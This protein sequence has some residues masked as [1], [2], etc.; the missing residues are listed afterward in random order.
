MIYVLRTIFF[1]Y[2]QQIFPVLGPRS[3][4]PVKKNDSH[5]LISARTATSVPW[6][7]P[8]DTATSILNILEKYRL[9]NPQAK[10]EPVRTVD[11][12]IFQ[13]ERSMAGG[14]P[15][16]MVLPAFPFKSANKSTKVLGTLPDKGEEVALTHLNNLCE[17]IG[18]VYK[19]GAR[20]YIISDGLVYNDILKVSDEEVWRYGQQLRQLA[21]ECGCDHLRFS[22]LCDLLDDEQLP[23]PQS[24]AEYVKYAPNFR[25]ET[26]RRY[27]P[28][29]FDATEA[30]ARDQDINYTYCGYVRFLGLELA[31]TLLKGSNMPTAHKIRFCKDIAKRMIH[32]GKAFSEAIACR[33]PN[34]LRLSIHPSTDTKKISI[35]LIPQTGAFAMTPWH[36]ALVRAVDGSITMQHAA[37]V[38]TKTHTL[39]SKD[40]KPCYFQ[41]KSD[42][43]I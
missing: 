2:L 17:E 32:R 43:S 14:E 15:V 40:G 33:F 37:K 12:F 10:S 30:I 20:L 9:H 38:S 42:V 41:E 31:D 16:S 29:G 8:S 11:K 19:H 22:R 5:V 39:I 26:L 18:K 23:E 34:H 1:D 35:S 25:E 28:E 24:E 4:T 3:I 7:E 21:R 6:A 36:S 27:L 13:I